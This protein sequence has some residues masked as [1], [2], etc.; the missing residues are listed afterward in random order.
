M[1]NIITIGSATRDVFLV[2][3]QFIIIPSPEFE[4]GLGECV[5]FGSKRELEDVIHST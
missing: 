3:K 4:T 5:S 2:S 1:H